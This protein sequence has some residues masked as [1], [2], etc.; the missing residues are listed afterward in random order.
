MG[1]KLGNTT[2]FVRIAVIAA[3]TAMGTVKV[4]N[5]SQWG[6]GFIAAA[7]NPAV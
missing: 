6:G 5:K 4:R 2:V 7:R 3:R 1:S